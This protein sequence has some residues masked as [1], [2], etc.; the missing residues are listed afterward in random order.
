VIGLD[1]NGQIGRLLKSDS[2]TNHFVGLHA[3]VPLP[4]GM[5]TNCSL[6]VYRRGSMRPPNWTI[7]DSRF[8]SEPA[9][10]P[11]HFPFV[12]ESAY[13]GIATL[14]QVALDVNTLCLPFHVGS[15][16][17][18][19]MPELKGGKILTF[20]PSFNL[21]GAIAGCE[22]IA[23]VQGVQEAADLAGHFSGL[24]SVDSSDKMRTE[25]HGDTSFVR[26]TLT[27]FVLGQMVDVHVAHDRQ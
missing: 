20:G 16:F 8:A 27:A 7:L 21:L 22:E 17:F 26:P 11:L 24:V 15:A 3:L 1:A 25:V 13:G 12:Y 19:L 14:S 9:V 18:N 5:E 6:L 10:L 23:L 4:S 2:L